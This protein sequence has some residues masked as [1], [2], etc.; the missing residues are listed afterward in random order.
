VDAASSRKYAAVRARACALTGDIFA[1]EP[2]C[3]YEPK[4]KTNEP[5]EVVTK[6]EELKRIIANSRLLTQISNA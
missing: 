6:R 2:Y 1:E 3:V 4:R 5:A